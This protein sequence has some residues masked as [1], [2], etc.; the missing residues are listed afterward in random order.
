MRVYSTFLILAAMFASA[1][2]AQSKPDLTGTWKMNME[3]SSLETG[4]PIPYYT[5]YV[6]EFEHREPK[7]KL[8]E[9]IKT[10]G[11]VADRTNTWNFTT[12]G[13]PADRQGPGSPGKISGTWEGDRLVTRIEA[14]GLV[15][16]RKFTLAADGKSIK[17][18]WEIHR[19]DS[20]QKATEFWEKQ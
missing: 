17:A 7:V 4:G 14:L 18:D 3:K 6:M 13:K 5:E 12:D 19:P 10:Q 2:H 1:A 8:V 11:G 20:V 9:K 15:F 16:I